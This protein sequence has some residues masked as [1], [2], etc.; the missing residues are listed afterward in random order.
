MESEDTIAAVT[1]PGKVGKEHHNAGDRFTIMISNFFA[2]LFPI[3]M[4]VICLQVVLRTLGRSGIG[5]GNQAWMDDLQWWLYGAA[6]LVGIGYAVTTNSHVRVDIF[7]EN[8]SKEKQRRFD[9][10]ALSWLFLPFLILCWDV[11]LH[12]AIASVVADEG[13][14]SPN[15]LHDLWILKLFMNAS[16]VLMAIAVWSAYVRNLSEL[17]EPTLW[18][19]LLFAFPSTMYLVNLATFYVLWIWV[20]L[21]SPADTPLRAIGRSDLFDEL[22][23]GSW[24]IKYTIIISLVVTI[25]LIGLARLF[26]RGSS[27]STAE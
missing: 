12:Y 11:T 5:P 8:F 14:S 26:D 17:T 4:A 1:D 18:K 10:L 20:Y 7:Y 9:V 2:W 21:T 19:Q 22:D 13:S 25:L 15:G 24:E 3:L 23:L 27:T 16:F 6:V